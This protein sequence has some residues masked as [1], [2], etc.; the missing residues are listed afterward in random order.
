MSKNS[1]CLLNILSLSSLAIES[2][3]IGWTCRCL[4]T[5]VTLLPAS[6]VAK[7]SHM[8]KLLWTE[9]R[10]MS[11]FL[12][13][14]LRDSGHIHPHPF[15]ATL[16]LFWSLPWNVNSLHWSTIP[17]SHMVEQQGG[18]IQG[19][20]HRGVSLTKIFCLNKIEIELFLVCF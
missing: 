18:Q 7:C 3:T 16:H 10:Y 19:H 13:S 6:F 20:C 17:R 15:P 4:P 14:S 5:G 11:E 2:S 8:E 9:Y 12:E 1:K